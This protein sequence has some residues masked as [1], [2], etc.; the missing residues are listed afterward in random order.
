MCT[1]T[2]YLYICCHPA[3]HRFRNAVCIA[4]NSRICRIQDGNSTL[5]YSCLSCAAKGYSMP[6]FNISTL[7]PDDGK[8]LFKDVWHIP[9]RCFVDVGFRTLDPF[10]TGE[11]VEGLLRKSP[12]PEQALEGRLPLQVRNDNS[13]GE[14]L[15]ARV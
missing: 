10:K 9:S 8:D 13:D 2:Q 14:K 3:T 7:E 12:V 11:D 15:K 4:P 1:T 6:I 5:P